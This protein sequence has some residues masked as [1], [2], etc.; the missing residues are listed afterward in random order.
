MKPMKLAKLIED[1]RE[2][3]HFLHIGKA[4]GS[5]M[6]LIA[7]KFNSKNA[8]FVIQKHPHHVMLSNLPVTAPYFFSVRDPVTRFVSGFYSRKR[9][10]QPKLYV[11]WTANEASAFAAFDHA[12]DLAEALFAPG[13]LGQQAVFAIKSISHTARG[14][15]DWISPMG[16][17]LTHRPPIAI[18]R[19]EHFNTDLALLSAHLGEDMSRYIT[20]NP[21]LAHR[22]DYSSVPELSPKAIA[23]L[24]RWYVQDRM[25]YTICSD[26][27][28]QKLTEA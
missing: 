20:A 18:L 27:M 28:E 11:E 7:R 25:F 16:Y 22:N 24:E 15:V 5:Q 2:A 17:F 23:N 4:A 26:W 19:Q 21:A 1:G 12:N 6:G 14:Q 3:L 9:K 13:D 10:G 8:R